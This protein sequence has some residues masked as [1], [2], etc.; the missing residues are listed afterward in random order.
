MLMKLIKTSRISAFKL[1]W[2]VL[3]D[4]K[5]I[6]MLRV[7]PSGYINFFVS[8][9]IGTAVSTLYERNRKDISE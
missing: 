6:A 1:S 2:K 8:Y 4:L 5:E 3:A 9:M 7:I